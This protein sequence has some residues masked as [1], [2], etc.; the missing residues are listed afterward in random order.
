MPSLRLKV[1]DIKT[2][3]PTVRRFT[4]AS[5][6][7]TALPDYVPGSHVTLHLPEVGRRKY[8]LVDAGPRPAGAPMHYTLGIRRDENGQGGSVWMHNRNVGDTL[9]ADPPANEFAT[10][11]GHG[12][13]VLIAGGIGITPILS[14]TAG[15]KNA[16]R[17]FRV[18]YAA[19]TAAEFAFSTELKALA[20]ENLML[21][22]DDQAGGVLDIGAAMRSLV[23]DEPVYICGPKPMI[24]AALQESRAHKWADGRLQFEL[25]YTMAAEAPSVP[26]SETASNHTADIFEV[27]IKSTGAAFPVPADKTILAVLIDA[28]ID[29]LHD[30][31]KGECGVC[32]VSVLEGIPDHRDTILSEAERAAGKLMQICVS[33]SKTPR[34][35][36]DL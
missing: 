11:R 28:G 14:L 19:R 17:P 7:G 30:C 35:V 8:S 12:A 2:E 26:V 3:T 23:H 25:F 16:G 22:A 29:P 1:I 6:D 21:H 4:L 24:K 36:I 9:D 10:A 5:A 33:R 34:L 18:I 31:D 20:G 15:F 27:V 13:I 32:Q